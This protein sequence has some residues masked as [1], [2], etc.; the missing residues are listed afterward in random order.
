MQIQAYFVRLN[1]GEQE[2]TRLLSWDNYG[3]KCFR[4]LPQTD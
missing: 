3:T 2:Q 4:I 1:H